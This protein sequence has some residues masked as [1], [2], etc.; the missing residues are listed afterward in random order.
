MALT[1]LVAS[2]ALAGQT[3][4]IRDVRLFDGELVR[5]RVSVIFSGD[6]IEAI[7]ADPDDTG[8]ADIAVVVDGAGHTLIPGLIDAHT[9]TFS[10]T[11]LERSLDFGVTTSID[12]G[13]AHP[14]SHA[15]LRQEQARGA[16]HVRADIVSAGLAVTV[17]GG[18]GTQFGVAIPTLAVDDDAA[19]FVDE[20]IAEGSEFIKLIVDDFSVVGMQFPTLSSAQAEAV[21]AAAHARGRLAVVHARDRE[22]YLVSSRAG[23]DG[24]VHALS[25]SLPGDE[26]LD[27]MAGHDPFVIPTLTETEGTQGRSG[28]T[29]F[30]EDDY[31]GPMLADREKQSLR[32]KRFE[33]P[34]VSFDFSIAL[35]SVAA[36]HDRGLMIVAG[37]DAP[38]P[39][40]AAGA[41][42]H[43]ELELLVDAGLTPLEALRAATANAADAFRLSDR[44]RIRPGYRADLLLVAGNPTESITDTRRIKGVWKA[45]QRH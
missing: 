43:R 32:R 5:E 37:T 15:P 33:N 14:Q 11:A 22:A 8:L 4:L 36:M 45:G 18:H 30:A 3:T 42:M 29:L 41:S 12:M 40:T 7:V 23:A 21:I 17:P 34:K 9:H 35:R 27:S 13:T 2:P 1:L 19:A 31:I 38:N 6:V 44:G 28:G 26:L 39:G 16:V 20:R 24:F 10:R 25:E